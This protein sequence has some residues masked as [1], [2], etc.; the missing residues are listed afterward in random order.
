MKY[1]KS[2]TDF[3]WYKCHFVKFLINYI[4]EFVREFNRCFMYVRICEIQNDFMN[5][6]QI[7]RKFENDILIRRIDFEN[8]N[9]FK[10]KFKILYV[11]F[12][13]LNFDDFEKNENVLIDYCKRFNQNLQYSNCKYKHNCFK[14]QFSTYDQ[15]KHD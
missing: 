13:N 6:R 8:Q 1:I 15:K 10:F 4:F 5:W 2:S 3:F 7:D 14:C 12:Y 11:F 9:D